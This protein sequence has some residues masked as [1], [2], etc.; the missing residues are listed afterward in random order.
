MF[1]ASKG[2]LEDARAEGYALPAFN[3]M[4]LE[5]SKAIFD[6]CSRLKAPVL[7]QV[8]ES[9]ARYAGLENIFGIVKQ[10]EKQASVSACIHL[11]HGKDQVL[12]KKC[13]GLGFKSVMVDASAFPFRKN[14]AITRKVVLAARKLGCSVE[15]ELGSLRN[16]KA[17]FTQ[18]GEAGAFVKKTGCDSLAV[19]IGTSHGAY[20][21]QGRPRLDLERL[22]AIGGLVSVPL[23][24]HGASSV[25]PALVRKCNRFGAKISG[26]RGV[27]EKSIKKAIK[28]GIAKIN[29][30]TDLR[31]AFT[32]G[33]REF[34]SKN[35]KSFD[36]REA[37]SHA[38]R[39]V[40]DEAESKI[41]M[42]GAKGKAK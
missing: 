40:Q 39:L 13:L 32:A 3:T 34:H 16:S 17:S 11:D 24:L 38:R 8:T 28:L 10:L 7:I 21:F 5:T 15:A 20:K 35:P 30:D 41:R 4:N 9:T 19:A 22:A 33:L 31:L 23:V 36:P 37:L 27:P 1:R 26:A 18:P 6:A 2:L 12:I 14:L 25:S 29:I 42:F